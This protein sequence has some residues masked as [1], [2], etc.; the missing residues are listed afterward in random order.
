MDRKQQDQTSVEQLAKAT[1][2]DMLSEEASTPE[3]QQQLSKWQK[4]SESISRQQAMITA[5]SSDEK[6]VRDISILDNH[7]HLFNLQN[8]IYDLTSDTILEHNRNH[9]QKS[10]IYSF[11]TRS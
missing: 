4:S 6:L 3:M 7:A 8:G 9:Y 11:H 10:F 1:T 2:K 5:A